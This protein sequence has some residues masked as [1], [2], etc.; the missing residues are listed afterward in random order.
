MCQFY[1]SFFMVML[2]HFLN[3]L[4]HIFAFQFRHFILEAFA[5]AFQNIF[6]FSDRDDWEIFGEKEE[7]SEEKTKGSNIE[8][9]LPNGWSI[10]DGPGRG[11]VVAVQR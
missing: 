6:D 10:I 3:E 2:V 1:S 5:I 7:T 9:D 8:S 4:I 11:K